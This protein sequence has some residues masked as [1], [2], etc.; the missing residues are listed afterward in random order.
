MNQLEQSLTFL[1][2]KS[3]LCITAAAVF[4]QVTLNSWCRKTDLNL[5]KELTLVLQIKFSRQ[6]DLIIKKS[7]YFNEV[8][9][10]CN[11]WLLLFSET[12]LK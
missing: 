2:T 4:H 12:N 10:K 8:F 6:E 3:N 11:I 7:S 5:I 1:K 9:F